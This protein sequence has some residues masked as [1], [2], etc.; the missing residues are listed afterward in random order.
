[1][2]SWVEPYEIG[3]LHFGA[4]L[5]SFICFCLFF[6]IL[7]FTS[8]FKFSQNFI[9]FAVWVFVLCCAYFFFIIFMIMLVSLLIEGSYWTPLEFF[10]LLFSIL[11]ELIVYGLCPCHSLRSRG[12]SACFALIYHSDGRS[13]LKLLCATVQCRIWNK[14][15]K[16]WLLSFLFSCKL[17]WVFHLWTV[18][19]I[20]CLDVQLR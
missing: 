12:C 20:W 1:M 3:A 8:S 11:L 9:I 4:R 2:A 7:F 14:G 15:I 19:S 13:Y 18:C 6:S 16:V 5:L 17:E 10:L